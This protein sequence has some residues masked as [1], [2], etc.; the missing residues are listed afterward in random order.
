MS[1]LVLGLL[2]W[3]G[4]HL[5][6]RAAPGSRAALQARLG[7]ASKGVVGALI[8]AGLVL[9]VVGYQRADFV[10]VWAPPPF[11][12]HLN[13]L[14]MLLAVWLF[15]LSAAETRIAARI[16]HPQLTAVKTWA[17]AHLLV[18]GDLASIVLFGGLL[19]WAVVEVVL[20]NRA[21]PAGPARP[22][23]IRG[24]VPALAITAVVFSAT[25]AVHGWLGVWP[26]PG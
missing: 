25:A 16:R 19:A 17:V 18:N 23:P 5:W 20:I 8:L 26:F 7:E 11:L 13:N 14:L 24:A 4:A 12:T 9:M 2:L 22:R 15:V 3:A 1:W 10:H 21:G 6:K